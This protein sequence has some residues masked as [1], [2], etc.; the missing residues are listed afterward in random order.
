MSAQKYLKVVEEH[1]VA[2]CKLVALTDQTTKINQKTF[3]NIVFGLKN[4]HR[5]FSGIH[6]LLELATGGDLFDKI[7][8][9]DEV[10]KWIGSLP[11][12]AMLDAQLNN[13]WIHARCEI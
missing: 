1:R 5:F 10:G 9:G 6:I 2:A 4:R 13:L 12:R 7:G 8:A 3:L 11:V